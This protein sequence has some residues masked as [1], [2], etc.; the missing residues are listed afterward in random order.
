MLLMLTKTHLLSLSLCSEKMHI[1]TSID[2]IQRKWFG[3]H[4]QEN[5]INLK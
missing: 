1:F 3:Q 4:M 5:L 2:E